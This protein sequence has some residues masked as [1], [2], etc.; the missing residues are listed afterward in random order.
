MGAMERKMPWPGIKLLFRNKI[1]VF[2][3]MFGSPGILVLGEHSWEPTAEFLAAFPRE[4]WRIG[5]GL[6]RASPAGLGGSWNFGVGKASMGSQLCP[7]LVPHLGIPWTHQQPLEEGLGMALGRG[8]SLQHQ[9]H[10]L[11]PGIHIPSPNPGICEQ[12]LHPQI[13]SKGKERLLWGCC[14]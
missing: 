11:N 1:P 9:E 5:K 10:D 8:T 3:G 6:G 12:E 4:V 14:C 7:V 13:L 2:S